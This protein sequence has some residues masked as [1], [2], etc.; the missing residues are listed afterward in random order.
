MN[1]SVQKDL[2]SQ[3]EELREYSQRLKQP[4]SEVQQNPDDKEL[5][6]S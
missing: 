4:V 3:L 6:Y 5:S 1:E 2:P